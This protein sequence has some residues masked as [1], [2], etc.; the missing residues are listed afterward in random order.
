MSY[1]NDVVLFT[2]LLFLNKCVI[3]LM[4]CG[5]DKAGSNQEDT[6][7]LVNKACVI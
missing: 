7:Q 3:I 2:N 5:D 4:L 6:V 1:N